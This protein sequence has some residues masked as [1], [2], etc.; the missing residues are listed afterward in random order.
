MRLR[1]LKATRKQRERENQDAENVKKGYAE[2]LK[3]K[4]QPKTSSPT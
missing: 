1:A 3:Q 4:R 2:L